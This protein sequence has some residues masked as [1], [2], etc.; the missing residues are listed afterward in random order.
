KLDP[1]VAL[2]KTITDQYLKA[3][4][5][6]PEPVVHLKA[7]ATAWGLSYFLAKGPNNLDGLFRYYQE[8]GKLPRDLE[9]DD[10]VLKGCFARAFQ[11]ADPKDPTK[12][13]PVAFERFAQKWQVFMSQELPELKDVMDEVK[14]AQT[15]LKNTASTPSGPPMGGGIV[16]PGGG[17]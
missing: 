16:P 1:K 17:I 13:D 4:K 7:K 2:E 6:S 8:L 14:K 11:L 12:I 15:D 5:D 9:F 10:D 3:A